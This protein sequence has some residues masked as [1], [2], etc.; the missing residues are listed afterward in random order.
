V[1]IPGNPTHNPE[2]DRIFIEELRQKLNA[3]IQIDEVQANME[4]EA[5]AR[6]VVKAALEIF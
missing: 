2:E 3:D 5:F 4:D 6:A 1:D